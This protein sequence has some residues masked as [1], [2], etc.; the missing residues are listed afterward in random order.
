LLRSILD[1]EQFSGYSFKHS[2]AITSPA[3]LPP[4]KLLSYA[5]DTLLFI[6]DGQDLTRTMYHLN[7]YSLVSN[8]KIN[9]HKIRA[10]SL[11]GRDLDNYWLSWLSSLDIQKIWTRHDPDA[12]IYLGYPL[13]QSVSQRNTF[14]KD[15]VLKIKNAIEIHKRRT[16]AIH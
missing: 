4:I 10:I 12:I 3:S 7:N 6:K 9:F 16:I 13:L 14:C 11:S 15:F 2:T 1:D 8:A 5:D